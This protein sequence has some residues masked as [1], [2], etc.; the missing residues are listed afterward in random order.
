MIKK[1]NGHI[2]RKQAS[3]SNRLISV[4]VFHP[5]F[6]TIG[7]CHCAS[8][9]ACNKDFW[10]S[11]FMSWKK[12]RDKPSLTNFNKKTLFSLPKN[13][14]FHKNHDTNHQNVTEVNFTSSNKKIYPYTQL[15][16]NLYQYTKWIHLVIYL[17]V[18]DLVGKFFF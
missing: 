12:K 9:F 11:F 3:K 14:Y 17:S 2:H 10:F 1:I 18:L 8:Q 16:L 5:L 6:L 13:R 4:L 15:K 7:F